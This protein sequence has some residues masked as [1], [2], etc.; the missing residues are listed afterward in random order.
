M[1]IRKRNTCVITRNLDQ[2]TL[3]FN[4]LEP[5]SF[6][7]NL[8]LPGLFS[9]SF[10]LGNGGAVG[11]SWRIGGSVLA[12]VAVEQ[13]G[14]VGVAGLSAPEGGGEPVGRPEKF[15]QEKKEAY[16]RQRRHQGAMAG[17]V[18]ADGQLGSD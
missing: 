8:T 16:S 18:W 12:A 11:G 6:F 9:M 5:L 1:R 15:A 13:E 10:N 3:N 2:P 14:S 17:E 7:E 4:P